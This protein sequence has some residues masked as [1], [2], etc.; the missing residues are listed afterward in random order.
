MALFI[1]DFDTVPIDD[2]DPRNGSNVS[3]AYLTSYFFI[4]LI[5]DL[6]VNGKRPDAGCEIGLGLKSIIFV[7]EFIGLLFLELS[8][9]VFSLTSFTAYNAVILALKVLLFIFLISGLT[10]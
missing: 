8:L 5:V 7:C 3:C 4:C 1:A 10:L 9:D 6:S 2:C